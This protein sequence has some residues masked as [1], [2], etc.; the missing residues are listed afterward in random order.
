MSNWIDG[1]SPP[2][3]G[4]GGKTLCVFVTQRLL[5]KPS[6]LKAEFERRAYYHWLVIEERNGK[7]RRTTYKMQPA[8][9]LERF[10]AATPILTSRETPEGQGEGAGSIGNRR[11]TESQ[12][13][14]YGNHAATSGQEKTKGLAALN[15]LTPSLGSPTWARTR[16]LRINRTAASEARHC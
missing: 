9:A 15:Q 13:A 16:D 6:A 11:P 5:G 14:R 3:L 7:Q 2:W 10:P 12:S 8:V 1:A 4:G